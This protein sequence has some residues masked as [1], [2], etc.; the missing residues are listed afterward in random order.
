MPFTYT[1]SSNSILSSPIAEALS[2]SPGFE[3]DA[4]AWEVFPDIEVRGKLFK[5][6]DVTVIYTVREHLSSYDEP[7]AKLRSY[8]SLL[9]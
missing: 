2:E 3:L 9:Q 4:T 6:L 7:T 1:P 5:A 8:L